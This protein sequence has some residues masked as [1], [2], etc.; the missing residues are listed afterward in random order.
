MTTKLGLT[1]LFL[2]QS[3]LAGSPDDFVVKA[4][5]KDWW[6]TPYSPI[7]FRLTPEGNR[8]L[9][10]VLQLQHYQF[11]IKE[12]NTKSLKLFLQMNKYIISPYY[13]KGQSTIIFYGETDATMMGLY[14]GDL[15]TYL[16][17]F[18]R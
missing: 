1:R 10:D 18:T 12:N 16:E 9:S 15:A 4:Y 14:A 2:E 6:T 7:G 11:K 8:F 13:L 3:G 17:N 5:M